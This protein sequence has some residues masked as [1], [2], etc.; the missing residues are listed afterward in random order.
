MAGVHFHVR[1]RWLGWADN[2]S[3]PNADLRFRGPDGERTVSADAVVLAL[4]GASWARLGSDG[5]W[6]PWLR[7][8]GVRIEELRPANCGFDVAASTA[9]QP[10]GVGWS[11]HFRQRFAGQALKSIAVR[12]VDH[13]GIEHLRTGEC[14][15]TSSGLEGSLIYALSAAIRDTIAALG[16]VEIS[17]DLAPNR[18][19]AR[20]CAELGRPRG[21]RS[22]ASHLQSK[23][24]IVGIKAG[25]LRECAPADAFSDPTRLATLIKALPVRLSRPRPLD[26]AI[27]T[28][29]G[30]V[31][32]DVDEHLMIRSQ[33]G[34]FCCGE[35]LDWEAPT[36][37]Y[38]LT[39]CIASGHAAGMGVLNRLSAPD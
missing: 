30:I 23:A 10:D 22:V 1:H 4:G 15:I 24:G 11:D 12:F 36:G 26:E 38:L 25:L 20:L 18:P 32:E 31:F 16:S 35:M 2:S 39:A 9:A 33:P 19:L 14:M 3:A 34:L 28:A 17:F 8:R 5:A 7:A 13:T 21:S 37:G 29:G 6:V 27:S